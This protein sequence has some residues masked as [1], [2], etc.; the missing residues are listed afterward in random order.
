[1]LGK[2]FEAKESHTPAMVAESYLHVA[3]TVS[4]ISDIICGV[5]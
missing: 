4:N 1:V 5:W 2:S 3:I